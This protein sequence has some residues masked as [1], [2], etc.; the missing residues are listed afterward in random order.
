MDICCGSG[1][2]LEYFERNGGRAIGIDISVE[3]CKIAK[4]RAMKRNLNYKVVVSDVENLPIKDKVFDIA[5]CYGGLHHLPDPH[6]GI[7]ELCRVSREAIAFIEPHDSLLRRIL[8]KFGLFLVEY[9]GYPVHNFTRTEVIEVLNKANFKEIKILRCLNY[10]PQFLK[11]LNKKGF[12][13]FYNII[14]SPKNFIFSKVGNQMIV[15]AH[16][17]KV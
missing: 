11:P 10:F 3:M 4:L 16:R 1:P 9:S 17:K 14:C 13:R 7:S 6:V 12:L 15:I 8:N 5:T 2:Q